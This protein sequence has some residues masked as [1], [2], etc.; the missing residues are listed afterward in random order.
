M[1]QRA[2]GRTGLTVS[3]LGLGTM[4]W[5]RHTSAQDA[6][7]QL[8]AFVAAGG[9]LVDTAASYG[10]GVAEQI[11]GD[12]LAQRADRCALVVATKAGIS[13][14]GGPRVIDTSR[15]ALLDALDGSLRRLRSDHVDLWQVH[16]WDPQ[17]PFDETL[18]ALDFAVT[19]GRA[20]Y[21]GVSNYSA[22]QLSGAAAWQGAWPGRAP[23][24]AIQVEYSLLRRT[25]EQDL[26]A[27]AAHHG[28]G[29][30]AWSPLANGVLTGKYRGGVP[31]GAR[32]ADQWWA[33]RVDAYLDERSGHIVDALVTASD[34]LGVPPHAVALGWVRQQPG[35]SGALIGARTPSQL[36]E[37]L[38]S[39]DT[40]LPAEI[41]QALDEVSF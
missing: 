17:V 4:T 5:G 19:S 38:T 30:L 13:R 35:I 21:V 34:G 8:D 3:Q 6:A 15:K 27:A 7:E 1:Q 25:G 20:R 12:L 29:I 28:A 40:V 33:D 39:A 18:A 14:R 41:I 2:L 11:L 24:C 36:R 37:L 9:T 23:I 10:D 26:R 22:W 16:A 32:G 31:N